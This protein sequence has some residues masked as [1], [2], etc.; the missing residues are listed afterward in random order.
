MK[1]TEIDVYRHVAIVKVEQ[2]DPSS[3]KYTIT[4]QSPNGVPTIDQLSRQGNL[5]DCSGRKPVFSPTGNPD[6]YSVTV[7][8]CGNTDGYAHVAI[9]D[10]VVTGE[11]SAPCL[12]LYIKLP[13][14]CPNCPRRRNTTPQKPRGSRSPRPRKKK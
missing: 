9:C 1:P 7:C 3:C 4:V 5:H 10:P 2:N 13:P 14:S 6:E 11:Y 12:I 8:F